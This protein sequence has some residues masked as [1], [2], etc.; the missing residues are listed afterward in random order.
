MSGILK[1]LKKVFNATVV[2]PI[3]FGLKAGKKVAM[4]IW[5]TPILR[6]IAIAVAIYFT[7]GAAA[8]Y[9]GAAGAA[10]GTAAAGTA[11]GSAAAAGT[12]TTV[13]GSI[14]TGGTYVGV[15]STAT[16]IGGTSFA[17]GAAAG[18]AGAAGVAGAAAA[19]GGA[20]GGSVLTG[21]AYTGPGAIAA[22]GGTAG[23]ASTIAYSSVGQA[24]GTQAA[25]QA[26]EAAGTG[27]TYGGGAVT[28]TPA[29]ISSWGAP[30]GTGTAQGGGS[31]VLSGGEYTGPGS[32]STGMGTNPT[33]EA[34]AASG[35][36]PV[37]SPALMQAS[38]AGAAPA[39]TAAEPQ[40]FLGRVGTGLKHFWSGTPGVAADGTPV[41]TGGMSSFEK[42]MLL[43][44]AVDMASGWAAN[45]PRTQPQFYGHTPGG[46]GSGLGFH[47]INNGFG[48]AY[49]GHEPSPGGVP[50]VLRPPGTAPLPTAGDY[51]SSLS[52]A[53]LQ[54]SGGSTTGN[55]GQAAA[56]QAGVGGLVPQGAVDYMG[57]GNG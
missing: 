17:A 28:G 23:E 43:K 50:D 4:K 48:L 7:A 45:T 52:N 22:G 42:I 41:V 47:T 27:M 16:Y 8:G 51:A 5:H 36:A 29:G 6:Y 15:G 12:A 13:G 56:N 37:G 9:F 21:A 24:A 11:A 26:A 31:G 49:G 33:G 14:L 20:A 2:K 34:L 19:E 25:Q 57:N 3:K 38:Q 10:G 30:A 35:G 39:A 32:L 53:A 18:A 54:S 40:G 55:L 44:S 46:G 1:A